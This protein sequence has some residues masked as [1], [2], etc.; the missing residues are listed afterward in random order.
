VLLKV[1][2]EEECVTIASADP[3]VSSLS[4]A[5]SPHSGDAGLSLRIS[6]TFGASAMERY[7]ALWRSKCNIICENRRYHSLFGSL[8]YNVTI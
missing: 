8:Q 7:V 2:K 3:S 4:S 1:G 6:A 5:Q